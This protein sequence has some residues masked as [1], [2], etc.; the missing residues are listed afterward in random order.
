MRLNATVNNATGDNTRYTV[1]FDAAEWDVNSD[2][3]LTNNKFV[4]PVDG[5]IALTLV[6]LAQVARTTL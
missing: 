2:F 6:A 5:I 1:P 3:D 4:A